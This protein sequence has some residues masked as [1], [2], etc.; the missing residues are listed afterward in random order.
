MSERDKRENFTWVEDFRREHLKKSARNPGLAA[1][2][3]FILM[4]TGQIYAG[5]IDRGIILLLI[6]VF[7]LFAGYNLY[8]GGFIYEWLMSSI[9]PH[10]II[11]ICYILS[12]IFIL[13][14]IYNIKDAYYLSIFSSFRDW[15]EVE[16]VL[17]PSMGVPAN[18]LISNNNN[19]ANLL[20]NHSSEAVDDK[21]IVLDSQEKITQSEKTENEKQAE[22]IQYSEPEAEADAEVINI[23]AEKASE[24]KTEIDDNSF[25]DSAADLVFMNSNT[26]KSYASLV[27]VIV[28]F[29]LGIGYYYNKEYGD[30]SFQLSQS[31]DV[32]NIKKVSNIRTAEI[33][34]IKE[35]PRN[36][37]EKSAAVPE[38]APQNIPQTQPAAMP[39]A[40]FQP[41][42][43]QQQVEN[44][45][46][47]RIRQLLDLKNRVSESLHLG[48]NNRFNSREEVPLIV[49]ADVSN[50]NNNTGVF[51][52]SSNEDSSNKVVFIQGHKEAKLLNKTS[53][54]YE[55]NNVRSGVVLYE[56]PENDDEVELVMTDE[57]TVGKSGSID[58]SN[59]IKSDYYQVNE[60][61]QNHVVPNVNQQTLDRL[62]QEEKA[63]K[64][65]AL[66]KSKKEEEPKGKVLFERSDEDEIKTVPASVSNDKP[67]VLEPQIIKNKSVKHHENNNNYESAELRAKLEKIKE[68]GAQEFYE[69]NWEAALPFYFEVLK[70]RRNAESFEMVGIIFEKMNKLKD[71]F[72]AYENAYSL[73]LDTNHNVAR[74]GIIAEKI[75]EYEKAQKYL[76]KAIENNPKRA[77]IILS[78]ARCL[79]KQGEGLA[80]AQV[81]AVLRDST[82]SYA[83][84]KAAEQE[85]QKILEAESRKKQTQQAAETASEASER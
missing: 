45:V 56:A 43:T 21:N 72:E 81:L 64:E 19:A 82:N 2:M 52:E 34:A 20:E 3:S 31:F 30:T 35:E 61:A 25:D 67:E 9:G 12:V 53:T 28:L 17:L 80:A 8:S 66:N 83:I 85:Y 44:Y 41:V 6:H 29:G 55:S 58:S 74:L 18:L 33:P 27:L 60:V 23:T 14:W 5:H 13:T 51:S 37:A 77:D 42:I 71:A 40:Y 38:T 84:K 22:K 16:R 10:L 54:G 70:H 63:E 78:Y 79:D 49:S 73:G 47:N 59:D 65:M 7:S 15:F 39:P 26:W 1:L 62:K 57:I 4:G 46:D 68:K 36:T 11:V 50:T 24:I 75:G 69:G 76:E 32:K 48:S